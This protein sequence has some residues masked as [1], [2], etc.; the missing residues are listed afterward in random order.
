MRTSGAS[1]HRLDRPVGRH[2]VDDWSR[3]YYCAVAALLREVGCVDESVRSLFSAG[4][5]PKRAD[6]EDIAL[7]QEHGL[8]PPN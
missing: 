3:G 2:A 7:F 6:A 5:D 8:M 1:E 4:G